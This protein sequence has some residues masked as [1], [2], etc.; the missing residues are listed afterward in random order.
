MARD[1]K[2]IIRVS[3]DMKKDF[4]SLAESM[5]MTMSGLGAFVVGNYMREEKHKRDMQLRLLDQVTPQFLDAVNKVDLDDPRLMQSV[6]DTITK[7]FIQ[8]K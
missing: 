6:S 2:I 8:N 3:E 7:L 5:G 4:Q 1:D